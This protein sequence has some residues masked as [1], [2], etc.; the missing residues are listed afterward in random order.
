VDVMGRWA[1]GFGLCR[2]AR[3]GA[4]ACGALLLT[5]CSGANLFGQ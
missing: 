5:H 4:A 2:I 1:A 3:V